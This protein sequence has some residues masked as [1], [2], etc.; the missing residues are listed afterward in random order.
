M[1][2]VAADDSSADDK[3]AADYICDAADDQIQIQAALD[4]DD[5]HLFDGTYRVRPNAAEVNSL[6]ALQGAGDNQII[7]GSSRAGTII[8]LYDTTTSTRNACAALRLASRTGCTVK[9]LYLS[10]VVTEGNSETGHGLKIELGGNHTI[11]N[12]KCAD[13]HGH[14][15]G[16]YSTDTIAVTNCHTRSEDAGGTPHGLDIDEVLADHEYYC[17]NITITDTLCEGTGGGFDS[18]KVEHCDGVTYTRCWFTSKVSATNDAGDVNPLANI[19][20]DDCYFGAHFSIVFRTGDI[21]VKNSQ[22]GAG[23]YVTETESGGVVYLTQ[24]LWHPDSALWTGD[25]TASGNSLSKR[26]WNADV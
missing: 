25:I 12:I 13:F 6:A 26:S 1:L 9:N 20:Y 22:F 23:G 8:E 15:M 2:Y 16:L 19:I 4:N 21:T 7:E 18:T 11:H 10:G 17:Q 24:N 5:V 3:D 14:P